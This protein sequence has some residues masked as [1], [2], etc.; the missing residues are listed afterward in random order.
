LAAELIWGWPGVGPAAERSGNGVVPGPQVILVTSPGPGEGKTAVV[1]NLAVTMAEM[2][3]KVLVLSCDLRRPSVHELFGIPN[4]HGLVDA[5]VSGNSGPVLDRHVQAT[6]LE[7]PVVPSGPPPERPSELLGSKKMHTVLEE[8]RGRAQIVLLDTSPILAA[9]DATY[10][11]P[12]VDAVLVV[13][14]AGMTRADVAQRTGELLRQLGVPV[15]GV[16]LNATREGA[17]PRGYGS[18][19]RMTEEKLTDG[20]GRRRGFPHLARHS[21]GG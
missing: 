8:A 6:T 13:A 15:M 1:A 3:Q 16:A 9:G 19:R 18:Y 17:V 4:D 12:S 2:S 11:V 7:I 14:R 10:L 21:R 5:L 20:N